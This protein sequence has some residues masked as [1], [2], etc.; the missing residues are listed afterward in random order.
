MTTTHSRMRPRGLVALGALVVTAALLLSGCSASGSSDSSKS[1]GHLL[2]WT[3][4]TRQPIAEAYAKAHPSLKITVVTVDGSDLESKLSLIARDP[5]SLPDVVFTPNGQGVEFAQ[6]FGFSA[7]LTKLVSP[8]I[9][10]GFGATLTAC[11]KNGALDCLPGDI[12]TQMLFYNKALFDKF[13]YTVPTTWDEYAALGAK[14]ATEHPGYVIG[15]CGDAFCPNV[16]YHA[17]NCP[18]YTASGDTNITVN[19][20]T[21]PNCARVTAMLD[22]LIANKTVATLS[23]FDPDMAT[24]GTDQKILMMPGFVWYGSL[25][26]QQT[27]KNPN[28]VIA[29]AP[30]PTWGDG[31]KGTGGGVGGQWI[32]SSKS[33]DTPD[34]VKMIEAM[35][36]D[37][38][39]LS[40]QATFPTYTPA[41]KVWIA[42]Q[43]KTG[44]YAVDPT[45][46]FTSARSDIKG[47]LYTPPGMDAITPFANVVAP[48]L[49]AGATIASQMSAWAAA[50][51]QT[52]TDAGYTVKV[53]K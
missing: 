9:K 2:V 47:N 52:A 50:I 48:K 34:A 28:G 4:A 33:G 16:Y 26:F 13:G 49:K 42:A 53:D 19:V 51:G 37:G 35:T 31:V 17:A 22:P 11:T 10:K 27:F 8:A 12:S 6:K 25:L 20:A 36:T 32:V 43:A 23:P 46:T 45:A 7:D 44:F 21:D 39:A 38:K 5:A 29:A 41:A 15:S 30:L 18:G 3:D 24:L 40:T 1:D 14:V